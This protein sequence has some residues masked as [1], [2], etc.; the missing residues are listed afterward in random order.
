MSQQKE[1]LKTFLP[2]K[3]A[4]KHSTT[5]N[6]PWQKSDHVLFWCLRKIN[7]SLW[8]FN[9]PEHK[10]NDKHCRR[11]TQLMCRKKAILWRFFTRQFLQK[12]VIYDATPSIA[13]FQKCATLARGYWDK[14]WNLSYSI[15]FRFMAKRMRDEKKGVHKVA[16]VHSLWLVNRSTINYCELIIHKG[17][18]KMHVSGWLI[19]GR[20]LMHTWYSLCCEA[21]FSHLKMLW[22]LFEWP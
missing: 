9:C 19:V 15:P 18:E 10:E 7:H 1:N 4:Y 17:A 16:F 11:A 3:R 6:W 22:I 14:N 5:T 13:L 12:M 21:G 8:S 20:S 2:L